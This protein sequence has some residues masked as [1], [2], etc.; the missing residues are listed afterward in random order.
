MAHQIRWLEAALADLEGIVEHISQDSPAY[1][2]VVAARILAEA[3]MLG[4]FPRIG[5]RVPEWDEENVRERIVYSY[6]LIYQ[7][8]ESEVK[9]LAV[10][11]GARLLPDEIR[12][13]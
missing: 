12:N 2:S 1:G 11:H 7:V 9:I 6:R 8:G 10:I 5:R 3:R 4:E 13:R